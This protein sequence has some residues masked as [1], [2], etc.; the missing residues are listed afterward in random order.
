MVHIRGIYQKRAY[1]VHIM[2]VYH[3]RAYMV[4]IIIWAGWAGQGLG[5]G[6]LA[7]LPL[8]EWPGQG[9]GAGWASA[10]QPG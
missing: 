6:G 1:M 7:G 5:L 9:L 3:E 8:V 10:G 2:G 4:H